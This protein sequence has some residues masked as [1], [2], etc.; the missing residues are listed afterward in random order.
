MPLD[1]LTQG[2]AIAQARTEI[3]FADNLPENFDAVADFVLDAGCHQRGHRLLL[4]T[5]EAFHLLALAV[6]RVERQRPESQ[7][8]AAEHNQRDPGFERNAGDAFRKRHANP[9]IG[10]AERNPAVFKEVSA[11]LISSR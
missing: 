8:D 5:D 9:F 3:H 7:Q 1:D 10:L 2:L 11:G 4:A 6:A